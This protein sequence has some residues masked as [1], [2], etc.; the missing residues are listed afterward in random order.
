MTILVLK[1][2]LKEHL[3]LNILKQSSSFKSKEHL[4]RLNINRTPNTCLQ[5]FVMFM[6]L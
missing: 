6:M 5:Y 3:N 1:S 2:A 4:P